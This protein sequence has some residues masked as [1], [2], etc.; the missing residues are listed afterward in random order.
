MND[1]NLITI[2]KH[3]GTMWEREYLVSEEEKDL[4]DRMAKVAEE[5]KA[6]GQVRY[7]KIPE[8]KCSMTGLGNRILQTAQRMMEDFNIEHKN[9]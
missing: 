7:A 4:L 3:E 8:K 6:Y 9:N 5:I 2:I 1:E